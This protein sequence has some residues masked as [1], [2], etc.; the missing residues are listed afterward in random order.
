MHAHPYDLCYLIG[1]VYGIG[2][3]RY[4][5]RSLV[6]ALGTCSIGGLQ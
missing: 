6:G 3:T 5:G 1:I 4:S 2:N